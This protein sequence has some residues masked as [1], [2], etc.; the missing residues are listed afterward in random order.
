MRIFATLAGLLLSL[1]AFAADADKYLEGRDYTLLASPQPTLDASKIE[2]VEAF[3]F[4]CGHCFR[5][6]PLVEEWQTK[7]KPDVALVQIHMQWSE[8]MLSYQ[9][10]Y[11]T[12]VNL[13]IQ[14][15]IRMPVFNRIHKDEKYLD[16]PEAWAEL[17]SA[18]GVSK[19]AVLSA[20]NSFIISDMM[21]KAD[22]RVKAF[23]I[24]STPQLVVD[25]KYLISTPAGVSEEE[26]QK[27]ML[28]TVDFLVAQVRAERAAKR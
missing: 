4:T 6:E 8:G 26:G 18:Y 24:S 13:K 21:S 12:A 16:T 22:A 23:K 7:Q 2:V 5:F 20:Y 27:R 11:Y 14:N 15:K 1:S 28:Q 9:R 19:Q 25:G 10:G 3:S 17:F